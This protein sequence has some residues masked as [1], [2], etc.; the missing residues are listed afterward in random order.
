M[1]PIPFVDAQDPW[2]VQMMR[3]MRQPRLDAAMYEPLGRA[4]LA[5]KTRQRRIDD[6]C[7]ARR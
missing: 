7:R 3:E 6:Y 4:D 1:D 2:N 5:G